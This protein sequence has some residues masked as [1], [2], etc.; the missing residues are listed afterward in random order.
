MYFIIS[1]EVEILS[2]ERL[3]VATLRDGAYF[4][5][6]A[7]IPETS[8][9]RTATARAHTACEMFELSRDDFEG[10]IMKDYPEVYDSICRLARARFQQ[11]EHSK[12]LPELLRRKS[13]KR[14]SI[15]DRETDKL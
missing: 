7:V 8:L 2:V 12:T 1:G 10:S 3:V 14:T 5:E 6:F 13:A 9:Y 11:L 4:G 15:I